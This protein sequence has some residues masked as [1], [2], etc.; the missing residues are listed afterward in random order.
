VGLEAGPFWDTERDWVSDEAGSHELYWEDPRVTGGRDPLAL[1]VNSCGKGVGGGSVHWA[2]F[3]PRLHPFSKFIPATAWASTGP[4]LGH[5]VASDEHSEL[6]VMPSLPDKQPKNSLTP[7]RT[8][9]LAFQR[10]RQEA[11]HE[12]PMEPLGV[13]RFGIVF[14]SRDRARQHY[15]LRGWGERK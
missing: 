4:I 7:G 15:T 3:T 12:T 14:F 11:C 10:E 13:F 1:G 9:R 2:A 8:M 6:L 5:S